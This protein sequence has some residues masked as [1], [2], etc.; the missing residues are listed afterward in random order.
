MQ[1]SIAMMN[2][3]PKVKMNRVQAGH[4]V[5]EDQET[6]LERVPLQVAA[7][8]RTPFVGIERQARHQVFQVIAVIL[9]GFQGEECRSQECRQAQERYQGPRDPVVLTGPPAPS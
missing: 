4:D 7:R 2:N 3:E 5:V 8:E 1:A 6:V 9:D